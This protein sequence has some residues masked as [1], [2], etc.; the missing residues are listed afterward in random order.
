MRMSNIEID[1]HIP[2]PTSS[3]R[4]LRFEDAYPF[5]HMCP[6]ESFFVPASQAKTTTLLSNVSRMNK[7]HPEKHVF[8]ARFVEEEGVAGTRI[9]RIE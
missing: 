5:K 1:T 8:K 2:F 3:R 7:R 4:T 6:G 9:W